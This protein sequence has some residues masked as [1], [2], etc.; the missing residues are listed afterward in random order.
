MYLFLSSPPGR[1]DTFRYH[2]SKC[3]FL[4]LCTP[5][6]EIHKD[7]FRLDTLEY[8][9]QF[10]R[11]WNRMAIWKDVSENLSCGLVIDFGASLN[12]FVM[13]TKLSVIL[14]SYWICFQAKIQ[15]HCHSPQESSNIH[16]YF[17]IPKRQKRIISFISNLNNLSGTYPYIL[18]LMKG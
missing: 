2:V 14:F 5:V 7:K 17:E 10:Q 1:K 13:D 4:Y 11:K 3:I 15:I 16:I 9:L 18:L 6:S 12:C 8:N